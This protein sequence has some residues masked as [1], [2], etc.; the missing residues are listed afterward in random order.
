MSRLEFLKKRIGERKG[1]KDKK[2]SASISPETVDDKQVERIVMTMKK[3]YKDQRQKIIHVQFILKN[4]KL[5]LTITK[6]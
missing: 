6:Q 3:K 4:H 2:T 5:T 1:R